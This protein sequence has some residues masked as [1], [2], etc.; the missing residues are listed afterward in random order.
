MLC[1]VPHLRVLHGIAGFATI[2]YR[3]LFSPLLVLLGFAVSADVD[4]CAVLVGRQIVH[5]GVVR[6]S[7]GL[8]G[9]GFL[10]FL[11]LDQNPRVGGGGVT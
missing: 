10:A 4:R 8:K 7:V 6:D 1:D 9:A 11:E 2:R 5:A 3:S